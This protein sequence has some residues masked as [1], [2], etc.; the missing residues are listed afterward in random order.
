MRN[1]IYRLVLHHIMPNLVCKIL[2]LRGV[3]FGQI[4]LISL[5]LIAFRGKAK[6]N[7]TIYVSCYR[8]LRMSMKNH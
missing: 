5:I 6:K 2:L 3:D 8:I 7:V 4:A 1:L